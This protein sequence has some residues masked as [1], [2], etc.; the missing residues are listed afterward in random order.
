MRF[1]L[2]VPRKKMGYII[3]W[4]INGKNEK[5]PNSDILSFMRYQHFTIWR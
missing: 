4:F 5:R 2:D 1:I 3:V